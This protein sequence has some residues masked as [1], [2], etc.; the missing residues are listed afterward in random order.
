M[1]ITI[2][3]LPLFIVFPISEIGSAIL[4]YQDF[5][6][7]VRMK[8]ELLPVGKMRSI[9]DILSDDRCLSVSFVA[10]VSKQLADYLRLLHESFI[11]IDQIN[12]TNIY[13]KVCKTEVT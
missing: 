2:I 13:I 1:V 4:E 9:Q 7:S 3:Y 12:E 6:K 11:A 8:R 10:T 5:S